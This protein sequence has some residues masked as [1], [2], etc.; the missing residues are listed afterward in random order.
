MWFLSFL[1]HRRWHSLGESFAPRHAGRDNNGTDANALRLTAHK[2][3]L[4]KHVNKLKPHF[5]K[6]QECGQWMRV[7]GF[8]PEEQEK[9]R[10]DKK[11]FPSFSDEEMWH[12]ARRGCFTGL[13]SSGDVHSHPGVMGNFKWVATRSVGKQNINRVLATIDHAPSKRPTPRSALLPGIIF[14]PL[15]RPFLYSSKLFLLN[16]QVNFCQI[17]PICPVKGFS[18]WTISREKIEIHESS[19]ASALKKKKN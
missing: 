10:E 13:F 2:S 7:S 6:R 16:S 19:R 5:F 12:L 4:H 15:W 3:I 18:T 14:F 9:R 1:N 17:G 8:S 11:R